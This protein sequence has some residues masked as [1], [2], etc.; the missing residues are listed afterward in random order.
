MR[1][2]RSLLFK[3][4]TLCVFEPPFGGLRVNV[5]CSS[6]AHWKARSGLPIS[7]NWTFFARCYGWVATSEKR[8]ECTNR[9]SI[10]VSLVGPGGRPDCLHL[11]YAK[12]SEYQPPRGY[13]QA[14]AA[15]LKL[16]TAISQSQ[17]AMRLQP[18]WLTR[19][20]SAVRGGRRSTVWENIEQP[21]PHTVPVTS[22][23]IRSI[24]EL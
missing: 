19:L 6:E 16:Y 1:S 7:V 3:F 8:W 9:R 13:S 4:W 2:Y 14:E 10:S 17:Q 12:S 15:N 18:T 22:T 11:W 20:R 21:A 23:T 24:T 5:R